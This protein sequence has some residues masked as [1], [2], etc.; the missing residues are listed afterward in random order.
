MYRCTIR[1]PLFLYFFI[2][3]PTLAIAEDMPP[4]KISTTLTKEKQ[5]DIHQLIE[6]TG[7][8]TII[9]QLSI[10]VV[11]QLATSLQKVDQKLPPVVIR[12]LETELLKVL[13]A[14]IEDEADGLFKELYPIYHQYYTDEEIQQLLTFYQTPLGQKVARVTVPIFEEGIA[15]S[16]AWSQ[17]KFPHLRQQIEKH[18]Q[19]LG[20]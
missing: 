8:K 11:Q 16:Q 7:I 18:F 4:Q 5:Q 13:K 6:L 19:A 10:V 14:E 2:F 12:L 15:T 20:R 9:Y 3:L 1:L 17:R